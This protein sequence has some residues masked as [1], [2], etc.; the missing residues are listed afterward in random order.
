MSPVVLELLVRVVKE[1]KGKVMESN[2]SH[3]KIFFTG[4]FTLATLTLIGCGGGDSDGAAN[5]TTTEV[6]TGPLEYL[7]FSAQTKNSGEELWRTDGTSEGTVMVKEINKA[8]D[9]NPSRFIKAGSNIFFLADDNV[10]GYELWVK[11]PDGTTQLLKDINTIEDGYSSIGNLTAHGD[12]LFFTANDG[13]NGLELWVS[14]GTAEGTNMVVDLTGDEGGSSLSWLTSK[15]ESDLYFFRNGN[16]LWRSNGTAEAT[17]Q[18]I[19]DTVFTDATNLTVVGG[20]L[21]FHA[22]I[23][24]LWMSDGGSA[25]DTTAVLAVVGGSPSSFVALDNNKLLFRASGS[26]IWVSDGTVPGTFRLRE[27]DNLTVSSVVKSGSTAF[28]VNSNATGYESYRLWKTDGTDVGTVEVTTKVYSPSIM[29]GSANGRIVLKNSNSLWVSDG[30]DEGTVDLLTDRPRICSATVNKFFCIL[31]NEDVE[32][33]YS[34]WVSDGSF[35]G[36]SIVSGFNVPDRPNSSEMRVIDNIV[37]F[38]HE[39]R[40][41][42]KEPWVS[43]GTTEGTVNLADIN[44]T[45][46]NDSN[47]DIDLGYNIVGIRSE[48]NNAYQKARI[49]KVL[50]FVAD[51]SDS[52]DGLWRTDG[53]EAGTYKVKDTNPDGEDDVRDVT[54]LGNKLLFRARDPEH[55]AEL[56]VSDGT[57]QGTRMVFDFDPG[58]E[59]SNP[60]LKVVLGDKVFIEVDNTL[61]VSDGTAA[62]TEIISLVEPDDMA[63]VGDKVFIADDDD[64]MIWVSDGTFAGTRMLN[65]PN[66]DNDAGDDT[67]HFYDLNGIALFGADD[68]NSDFKLWRS[69]GTDEGTWMVKDIYP[70]RDDMRDNDS[71]EMIIYKGELYFAARSSEFGRELWKS[72]G[73]EEGTVMVKD[74][75]T[76]GSS[77]PDGSFFVI[78]NDLLFFT[79]N[80]GT[81][82]TE[83]WKTDGTEEGTSMVKDIAVEMGSGF[84][85]SNMY[86]L[87]NT[88]YFR[89]NDD[90]HGSELWK[91][92]G[93]EAGTIMVKDIYPE[94]G[95]GSSPHDFMSFNGKLY[96]SADDGVH[97]HELWVTDGTEEGTVMIK[98]I[99]EGEGG[100]VDRID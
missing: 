77:S 20:N 50:Y 69:D 8:G 85:S 11:K 97:G 72:D 46:S 35:E 7:Y 98:D 13:V 21:F 64:E 30:T 49:G 65:H 52:D 93:T 88:L 31:N 10:H 22:N 33:M 66:F 12:L 56:W 26:E 42:G 63:V 44:V 84:S 80:D 71:D 47:I 70:G 14:N 2:H 17:T 90:V 57:E 40:A 6:D 37:Y 91:T 32:D 3:L 41:V 95:V 18:V 19:V 54:V 16:E 25:G 48:T 73:T 55:G 86:V 53:T 67:E 79:A 36:T 29:A 94:A 1:Q 45:P 62:G 78:S 58:K 4:L 92:D 27:V 60:S 68:D 39:D 83:L 74:I 28:F 96:F 23:N 59:S 15:P 61:W 43:D 51:D 5:T 75:N 99:Y 34:L 89:A 87:G 24:E 76:G 82:G 100:Y 38:S 81:H 9:S